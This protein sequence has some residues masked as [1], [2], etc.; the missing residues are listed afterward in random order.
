M[1]TFEN[2]S[3]HAA[4][5]FSVNEDSVSRWARRFNE[6]GIDG[7]TEGPRGD[8]LSP[9]FSPLNPIERLWLILKA[10]WFSGFYA[11]SLDELIERLTRGLRWLI[12][13]KDENRNTSSI[14]TLTPTLS[15]GERAAGQEQEGDPHYP[16][17][18]P[19]G[20]GGRRP[21]E[22]ISGVWNGLR[23]KTARRVTLASF[24]NNPE[25][26]RIR[27]RMRQAVELYR[28]KRG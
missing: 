2:G 7:I 5:L 10:H 18:L 17:P 19:G 20:E 11:K 12:D 25:I 14:P 9:C 16:D 23:R 8:D 22:G 21:G 28:R 24:V 6:R 27:V 1:I 4:A 26:D 15:Q 13:R 3:K